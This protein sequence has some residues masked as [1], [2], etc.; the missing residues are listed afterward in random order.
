MGK[1]KKSG[2]YKII[3]SNRPKFYIRQTGQIFSERFRERLPKWILDEINTSF[4]IHLID[5]DHIYTSISHN[6]DVLH[7]R[8]KGHL[9]NAL[10]ECHI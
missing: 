8:T 10:E 5:S 6:L 4:V 1:Y 7:K 2:I 3:S 9:L